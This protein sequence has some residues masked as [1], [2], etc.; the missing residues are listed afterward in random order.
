[1]IEVNVLFPASKGFPL[2]AMQMDLFPVSTKYLMQIMNII[3]CKYLLHSPHDVQEKIDD[4]QTTATRDKTPALIPDGMIPTTLGQLHLRF[5]LVQSAVQI[6]RVNYSQVAGCLDDAVTAKCEGNIEPWPSFVKFTVI[7]FLISGYCEA[8]IVLFNIS[9]ML[10]DIAQTLSSDKVTYNTFCEEL[11][12]VGNVHHTPCSDT[13]IILSHIL[14]ELKTRVPSL[15]VPISYYFGAVSV[16]CCEIEKAICCVISRDDNERID[17]RRISISSAIFSV[18]EY[19]CSINRESEICDVT[20]GA[21]KRIATLNEFFKSSGQNILENMKSKKKKVRNRGRRIQQ[22]I[23]S[24]LS[25]DDGGN[26]LEDDDN[27]NLRECEVEKKEMEVV[28]TADMTDAFVD[29]FDKNS[30][31][32]NFRILH[33]ILSGV[34]D[35][36]LGNINRPDL[37][38]LSGQHYLLQPDMGSVMQFEKRFNGY[39]R[40]ALFSLRSYV[41]DCIRATLSTESFPQQCSGEHNMLLF[42]IVLPNFMQRI[43]PL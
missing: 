37:V 38:I 18:Y 12:Y 28:Q 22:L 29:L 11:T 39:I 31:L 30:A 6:L 25:D 9:K 40:H 3:T 35:T 33:T 19:L 20:C 26:T 1:M 13:V 27:T 17:S 41:L 2:N 24:E 42:L 23:F 14:N 10:F 36:L 43:R 32:F 15:D 5:S 34:P 8:L 16:C 4:D 7:C 21:L